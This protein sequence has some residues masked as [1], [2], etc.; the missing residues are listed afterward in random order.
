MG[1]EKT[2]GG[3][4]VTVGGGVAGARDVRANLVFALTSLVV[5]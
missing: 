4:V 3:V 5:K 1:N 2:G